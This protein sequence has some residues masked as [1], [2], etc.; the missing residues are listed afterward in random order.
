[1]H[2]SAG[3][4]TRTIRNKSI[5]V[6]PVFTSAAIF[7][8]QS[9]VVFRKKVV[10]QSCTTKRPSLRLAWCHGVQYDSNY[11]LYLLTYFETPEPAVYYSLSVLYYALTVRPPNYWKMHRFQYSSQI[12]RGKPTA[13][14]PAVIAPVTPS[15]LDGYTPPQ[16]PTVVPQLDDRSCAPGS[17][18]SQ[19][20]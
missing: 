13:R 12:F 5:T 3:R 7:H 1:M 4:M 16:A 2:C 10:V 15:W 11:S 14:N 9:F 18:N 8:T 20:Q 17:Y 6:R 19:N